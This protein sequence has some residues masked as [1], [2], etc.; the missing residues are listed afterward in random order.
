MSAFM[1]RDRVCTIDHIVQPGKK[2][3]D[4]IIDFLSCMWEYAK[5]EITRTIGA[6]A[7]LGLGLLIH[8]VE[9]LEV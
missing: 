2:A 9:A 3:T 6:V 8:Y 4:L 5:E 1:D 7:D